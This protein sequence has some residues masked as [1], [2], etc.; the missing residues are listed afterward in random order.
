[1]TSPLPSSNRQEAAIGTSS[2]TPA[3]AERVPDQV[4]LALNGI[5]AVQPSLAQGARFRKEA[6]DGATTEASPRRG[7]P[8]GDRTDDCARRAGVR[9]SERVR[10]LQ[11]V[12]HV[13][14]PG[15]LERLRGPAAELHS[16]DRLRLTLRTR[17]G[18]GAERDF[19]TSALP[20][21][22][23]VAG[24]L[25]GLVW[26]AVPSAN[27]AGSA[28]IA[29]S[30]EH[31]LEPG[32]LWVA[33]AAWTAA[34]DHIVV[35]DP[36]SAVVYFYDLGGRIVRRLVRPGQ[37]RLEFRKPAYPFL[38][39]GRL[40]VGSHF[41]HWVWLGDDLQPVDAF[42]LEWASAEQSPYARLFL[43][44]FDAGGTR[45]VGVG[46]AQTHAGEWSETAV[47]AAPYARKQEPV[48]NLGT[49]EVDPEE[50]A[51]LHAPPSEVAACGEE[52]YVLRVRKRLSIEAFG[53]ERRTLAAFPS[54]YAV[55]PDL[56]PMEQR[57]H[58]AARAA[59]AR[60][61][62][63]TDGLF[64]VDDRTLLLLAH[65]PQPDGSIRWHVFPIDP[66]ADSMGDP[67]ELPTHAAEIVFVPGSKRW[68]VLEKGPMKQV[69]LQPLVR[70]VV[71]DAPALTIARSVH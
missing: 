16:R 63:M 18:G 12:L 31:V 26:G 25:A 56:P 15:G 27:A 68:A 5:G 39:G 69:G 54:T 3:A 20:L 41:Y 40:L 67:I 13:G 7:A 36:E 53:R 61:S 55:R 48:V 24:L 2:S 42:R 34:E 71:F 60:T 62:R 65:D 46:A 8:D 17:E 4:P 59:A 9:A 66:V 50:S 14:L 28:N 49:L 51:A 44:S 29:L 58:V 57:D 43:H 32:P 23:A 38:V 35:A 11:R 21:T 52:V 6:G 19:G 37:G 64:C 33:R 70:M 1:M 45:F 22:F 30:T 47:W 10:R